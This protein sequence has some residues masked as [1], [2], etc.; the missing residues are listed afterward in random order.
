MNEDF[1]RIA[2]FGKI[3]ANHEVMRKIDI[4]I[5]CEKNGKKKPFLLKFDDNI[6]NTVNEN[7]HFLKVK[8]SGANY[9]ALFSPGF[10]VIIAGLAVAERFKNRIKGGTLFIK[11]RLAPSTFN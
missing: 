8:I 2:D 6:A 3:E 1:K 5:I 7:R 11:A 9:V 10:Q 4:K